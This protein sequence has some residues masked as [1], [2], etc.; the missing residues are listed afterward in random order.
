M[1]GLVAFLP[2]ADGSDR[3]VNR[4][5]STRTVPKQARKRKASLP[6]PRKDALGLPKHTQTM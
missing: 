6:E 3:L 5:S 4:L 2:V 1:L